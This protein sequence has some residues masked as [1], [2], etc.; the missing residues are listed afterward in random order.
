[1]CWCAHIYRWH[2]GTLL[3]GGKGE[4]KLEQ[5]R[6]LRRDIEGLR[7]KQFELHWDS[8]KPL[9]PTTL[10]VAQSHW[11][12]CRSLD[13]SAMMLIQNYTTRGAEIFGGNFSDDWFDEI[14][15]RKILFRLTGRGHGTLPKSE[16]ESTEW[17]SGEIT[18]VVDASIALCSEFELPQL[19]RSK[20][21]IEM[22]LDQLIKAQGIRRKNVLADR[23]KVHK[24]MLSEITCVQIKFEYRLEQPP[25]RV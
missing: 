8:E 5:W 3:N 9:D 18:N 13:R 19:R 11:S 7:G 12:W 15:G 17:V 20:E 24:G 2:A 16:S 25:D 1:M 10:T 23:A 6:E 14:R 4:T 22:V 21:D